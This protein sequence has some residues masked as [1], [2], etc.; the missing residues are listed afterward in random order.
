MTQIEVEFTDN[1]MCVVMHDGFTLKETYSTALER[2][3]VV[4]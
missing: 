2:K 4:P 3:A 1:T